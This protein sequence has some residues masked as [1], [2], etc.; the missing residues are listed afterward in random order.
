M[1]E[2]ESLLFFCVHLKT[3]KNRYTRGREILDVVMKVG[4]P[5]GL[6]VREKGT[7]TF[8]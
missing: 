1:S 8:W 3:S 2:H 4:E 5:D 6:K 7:V